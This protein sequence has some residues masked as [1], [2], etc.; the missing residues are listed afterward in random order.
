MSAFSASGE[1]IVIGMTSGKWMVLDSQTREVY[2]I[3]QDGQEP[4]QTVRFSP[5]DKFLAS[6]SGDSTCHVWNLETNTMALTA[7]EHGAPV[8]RLKFSPDG[9]WLLTGAKDGVAR[10]WDLSNGELVLEVLDAAAP[11]F[12]LDFQD[13]TNQLVAGSGD[14]KLRL[15]K[16]Y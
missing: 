4:I 12:A 10:L 2:G 8:V 5:N 14:G 15:M 16:P 3:Y 6:A 1:I 9:R 11:V 13:E 7:L